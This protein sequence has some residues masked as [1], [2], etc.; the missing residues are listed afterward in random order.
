MLKGLA[1][2]NQ[3]CRS[4]L[5]AFFCRPGSPAASF[6][7]PVSPTPK[8]LVLKK[9]AREARPTVLDA[10]QETLHQLR[11]QHGHSTGVGLLLG[12]LPSLLRSPNAF[13][14]ALLALPPEPHARAALYMRLHTEAES[15]ARPAGSCSEHGCAGL[16][17][18]D[19]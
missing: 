17:S 14:L 6:C 12:H 3:P 9:T 13:G 15:G 2:T 16:Q 5:F 10:P 7:L 11:A 8:G 18:L 4:S 1:L 19:L